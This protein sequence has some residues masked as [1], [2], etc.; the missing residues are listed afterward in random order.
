ME[1]LVIDRFGNKIRGIQL[2]RL[3]GCVDVAK[4]RNHNNLNFRIGLF[5]GCQDFKPIHS[6]HADIRNDN[7]RRGG[8]AKIDAVQAV[9]GGPYTISRIRQGN[10]HDLADTL[11]IVN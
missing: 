2:Q 9:S 1:G 3:N 4:S 5:K 10:G 11:F 8:L 6:G 7:L